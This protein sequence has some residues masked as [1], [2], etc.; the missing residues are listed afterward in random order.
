MPSGKAKSGGGENE[1]KVRKKVEKRKER[2]EEKTEFYISL[3]MK[4]IAFVSG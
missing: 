3:A 1:N 4:R 2:C